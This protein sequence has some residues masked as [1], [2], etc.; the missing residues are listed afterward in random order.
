LFRRTESLAMVSPFS[1]VHST[2]Q[3]LLPF[4]AVLVWRLLCSWLLSGER[5]KFE[6]QASA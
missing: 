2:S 6:S 1:Y 5:D 4:S 3:E